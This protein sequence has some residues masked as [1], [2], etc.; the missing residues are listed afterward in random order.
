MRKKWTRYT[1]EILEPI[2]KE[3]RSF[4][5]VIKKLNLK[6]GG[7]TQSNIKKKC[8][9]FNIDY[10][11]L[12]GQGWNKYGQPDFNKGKESIEQYFDRETERKP[13]NVK[14]RIL[15]YKL[16]EYKCELCNLKHEKG[17]MNKDII[18]ELHHKDGNRSNNKLENLQFLCPN[19][20]SQT[21][22]Y[23]NRNRAS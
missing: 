9:K 18:I 2:I 5:E 21:S 4:A 23:R 14:S 8:Q 3:S 12:L 11:H 15:S 13:S 1:K 22:N 7:G 10:S 6:Q 19:C 20:H 17:W 16:K